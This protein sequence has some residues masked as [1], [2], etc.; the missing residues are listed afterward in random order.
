MAGQRRPRGLVQ[1]WELP[2]PVA[3]VEAEHVVGVLVELRALR[4]QVRERIQQGVRGCG[5]GR[6]PRVMG[7]VSRRNW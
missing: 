4:V 5:H 2:M 6:P 1:Q 7:P 3:V